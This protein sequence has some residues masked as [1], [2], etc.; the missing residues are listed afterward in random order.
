MKEKTRQAKLTAIRYD[1]RLDIDCNGY[2]CA[3]RADVKEAL[4]DIQALGVRP[5]IGRE[6]GHAKASFASIINS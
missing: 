1:G 3:S 5:D 4:S 2:W 6:Y